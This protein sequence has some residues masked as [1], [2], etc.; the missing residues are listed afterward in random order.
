MDNKIPINQKLG[1]A[2]PLAG[3]RN[4]VVGPQTLVRALTGETAPQENGPQSLETSVQALNSALAPPSTSQGMRKPPELPVATGGQSPSPF[5]QGMDPAQASLIRAEQQGDI[6]RRAMAESA[7]RETLDG[8][9]FNPN[10][11]VTL[12]YTA[13]KSKAGTD[14]SAIR[15][16]LWSRSPEQLE[17]IAATYSDRYPGRDMWKD[18]QA[19]FEDPNDRKILQALRQ[20]DRVTAATAAIVDAKTGLTDS[21]RAKHVL[22]RLDKDE[23]EKLTQRFPQDHPKGLSLEDAV[24]GSRAKNFQALRDRKELE[25]LLEG[26]KEGARYERFNDILVRG[27][28]EELVETLRSYTPEQRKEVLQAYRREHPDRSDPLERIESKFGGLKADESIALLQGDE[29]AA[30]AALVRQ[31]IKSG[32]KSKLWE[33]LESEIADPAERRAYQEKVESAYNR[34]YGP[35]SKDNR[36]SLEQEIDRI[37]ND[38]HRDRARTLLSEGKLPPEKELVYA[39]QGYKTDA[40][41]VARIVE[42]Y[43]PEEARRMYAEATISERFPQGKSLD[44]AVKKFGGRDKFDVEMAMRGKPKS[45][46]EAVSR[47]RERAEFEQPNEGRSKLSPGQR[48]MNSSH[49]VGR[50]INAAD[51]L[52]RVGGAFTDTDESMWTNVRRAESALENLKKAERLGDREQ[53]ELWRTKIGELG[54]YNLADLEIYRAEKDGAVD[55]A[56]L[57]AT[58][59]V[60]IV[61]SAASFGTLSAPSAMLVAGV[62]G[63]GTKVG[64]KTLGGG[65]S[66]DLKNE[67]AKDFASGMAEAGLAKGGALLDDAVRFGQLANRG[68]PGL[69]RS[70]AGTGADG[71]LGGAGEAFTDTLLDR[72]TWT[73]GVRPGLDRLG[74]R[75]REGAMLGGALGMSLGGAGELLRGKPKSVKGETRASEISSVADPDISGGQGGKASDVSSEAASQDPA[76]QAYREKLRLESEIRLEKARTTLEALPE[77]DKEKLREIVAELD[78]MDRSYTANIRE[79]AEGWPTSLTNLLA[80]GTLN[81]VDSEGV[82]V[83]DRLMSIKNNPRHQVFESWD[84]AR[85]LGETVNMLGNPGRIHQGAYPTCAPATAQFL[86]LKRDP[87]DFARV[88]DQVTGQDGVTELASGK[89]MELSVP[90]ENWQGKTTYREGA[91]DTQGLVSTAYQGSVA[92]MVFPGRYAG[93]Y[94]R[95]PDGKGSIRTGLSNEQVGEMSQNLFGKDQKLVQGDE[96]TSPAGQARFRELAEKLSESDEQGIQ[97]AMRWA[98]EGEHVYHAVAFLGLDANGRAI[99]RNSQVPGADTL[100]F[101]SPYG[102]GPERMPYA[103]TTDEILGGVTTMDFEELQKR[104]ISYVDPGP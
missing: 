5:F 11:D 2:T 67:G 4:D 29:A 63:G 64:M 83:L 10:A 18:L 15:N 3:P 43:T 24:L 27:K 78:K 60:A 102:K 95:L 58:T 94:H 55:G 46:E 37:G 52:S 61:A 72:E 88:I 87:A 59:G 57:A 16:T 45:L 100:H 12:F 50:V 19:E 96:L 92:N 77:A 31:G 66:Y 89:V 76:V 69:L 80:D 23:L 51:D 1:T 9:P 73:D 47:M 13:G 104:M 103:G 21:K 20:G 54:G 90:T 53:V 8:K 33:G 56:A 34:M 30:D 97:I 42:Q 32:D 65:A 82:R 75:T 39:V 35:Q 84:G 38:E 99:V 71:A 91:G 25:A 48:I 79:S 70:A 40:D 93:G 74:A 62:A 17:A 14:E 68:R 22:Q 49:P 6:Q 101:D 81:K 86:H 28:P 36:R 26:D 44:E 85:I 98:D 7:D 41:V